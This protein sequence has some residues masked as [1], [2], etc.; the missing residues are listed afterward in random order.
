MDGGHRNADHRHT[1]RPHRADLKP[2]RTAMIEMDISGS[3]QSEASFF[4]DITRAT[5]GR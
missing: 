2:L 5:V 3:E 4:T 1:R